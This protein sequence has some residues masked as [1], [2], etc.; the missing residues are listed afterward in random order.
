[1]TRSIRWRIIVLQIVALLV[2]AFGSGAA[3]FANGFT[4]TQIHD[5]LAPQQI[6]FPQNA[7]QGLPKDLSQYAGQQVLTGEQAHAYAEQYI[8]LHLSEIGQGHPYSYWSAQARAATDP[9]VAAKDQAIADTLFKGETLRSMLNQAWT[10]SVI[11]EIAL[12]AGIAFAVAALIVLGTLIFEVA[13]M[14]TGKETV[15]AVEATPAVTPLPAV[16]R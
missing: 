16:A 2:L 4:T 9:T 3:F 11:A 10:F 8:G 6:A 5:Q 1:M 7:A 12:I 14:V 15:E 13:E